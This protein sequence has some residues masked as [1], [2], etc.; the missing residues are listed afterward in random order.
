ML[1]LLLLGHAAATAAPAQLLSPVKH[2]LLSRTPSRIGVTVIDTA[3]AGAGTCPDLRA[4]Q[5]HA[6]TAANAAPVLLVPQRLSTSK[7]QG[8]SS[9][10]YWD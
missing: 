7:Q 5:Q 10:H 1:L 4:T 9:T 3:A 8:C 2:A 6:A